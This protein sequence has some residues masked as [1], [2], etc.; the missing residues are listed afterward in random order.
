MSV[1]SS[2]SRSRHTASDALCAAAALMVLVGFFDVVNGLGALIKSTYIV[3]HLF[4]GSLTAWG[5]VMLCVGLVQMLLAFPLGLDF[6]W[7]MGASLVIV[8][9]G[10]VLQINCLNGVTAWSVLLLVGDLVILAL[11]VGAFVSFDRD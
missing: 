3:D 10:T 1:S 2:I 11:L 6:R 7:P 4:V 5:V 8:A 9:A